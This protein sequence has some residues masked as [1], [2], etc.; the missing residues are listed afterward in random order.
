MG[1]DVSLIQDAALRRTQELNAQCNIYSDGSASAGTA[2]GGAG[3]VI[4]TGDI[5]NP[6]IV[7]NLLE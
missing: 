5:A 2:D 6:T 3:V 7:D 4:T 1:D